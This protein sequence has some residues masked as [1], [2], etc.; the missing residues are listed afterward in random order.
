MTKTKYLTPIALLGAVMLSTT[1]IAGISET[2][3]GTTSNGFLAQWQSDT[4]GTLDSSVAI[5]GL[6]SNETIIGID[7][8]PLDG[9][10]FA[11]GSSSRLYTIDPTTGAATQVGG[12]PFS[13]TVNGAAFG[14]DFNPTIDRARLVSNSDQNT[15]LNPN[16]GMST[17]VTSLAYNSGDPN[18][19][20]NPNIVHNA[21]TNST[22]GGSSST[23]QYAFDS[24]LD[25]LVTLDNNAGTLNTI[26]GIGHNITSV[27]GFDISGVSGVAY[28]ALQTVD[29]PNSS[30]YEV[31]LN[32]GQTTLIGQIDGGVTITA[33]T[34][35]IPIPAPGAFALL[36]LGG[37][38]AGRKRR[39]N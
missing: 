10:L 13:N 3:Y 25:I 7:Y 11:V 30:F 28:A 18:E 38:C 8:R 16:D 26:G 22:F 37:L 5:S 14:F 4:P 29:G 19:G 9:T 21:Y 24:G 15:V 20:L 27:G 23:T 39:R 36:G 2:V 12:G 35:N 6:Q 31:D 32:T 1:A 17:G 33:M 34:V